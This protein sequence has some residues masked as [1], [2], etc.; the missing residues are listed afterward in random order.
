MEETEHPCD[1]NIILQPFGGEVFLRRKRE[2]AAIEE[3]KKEKR[4]EKKEEKKEGQKESPTV[5]GCK[6]I[7]LLHHLFTILMAY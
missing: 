5:T 3:D 4:E 2:A 1:S 6:S 7:T